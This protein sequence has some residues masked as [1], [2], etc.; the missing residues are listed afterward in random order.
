MKV[1]KILTV[2]ITVVVL[3]S[4]S[5]SVSAYNIT[6]ED[7]LDIGYVDAGDG[8]LYLPPDVELPSFLATFNSSPRYPDFNPNQLPWLDM[9]TYIQDIVYSDISK[10]SSLSTTKPSSDFKIPFVCVINYGDHCNVWVGY[11]LSFGYVHDNSY[12]RIFGCGPDPNFSSGY[13]FTNNACY[14]ATYDIS[15]SGVITL[16]TDFTQRSA[17]KF[18]SGNRMVYYSPNFSG[19][20]AD[21]YVY[22]ANAYGYLFNA[23]N[24]QVTFGSMNVFDDNTNYPDSRYVSFAQSR[25]GFYSGNLFSSS[26]TYD[27]YWKVFTPATAEDLERETSKNI[28]DVLRSI[29]DKIEGFFENLKNYL[30]YFQADKPE[31]VNPFAGILDDVQSFFDEQIGDT[32]EFKN[33]LNSTFENV[34][35]YISTGSSVINKLLDGVPLLNA[36]LIFFL[37]ISVIRKVVGR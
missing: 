15:D 30:L 7:W 33:S 5:F 37:V 21:F 34:S 14:M 28:L 1:I 31:H 35:T 2:C 18:Y 12:I 9:P 24:G 22:G 20:S 13:G 11:N 6:Y 19:S 23:S 8:V 4:N 25:N 10:L 26:Q 29:P 36:F 3:L 17:S 16:R 27:F 32:T